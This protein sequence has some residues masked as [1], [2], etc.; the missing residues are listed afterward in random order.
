MMLML[1]E[2]LMLYYNAEC[3]IVP[4]GGHFLAQYDIV[5]LFQIF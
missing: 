4:P 1:I 2:I 5:S 3:T